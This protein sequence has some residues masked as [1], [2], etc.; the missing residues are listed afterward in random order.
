MSGK[1]REF[2]DPTNKGLIIIGPHDAVQVVFSFMLRSPLGPAQAILWHISSITTKRSFPGLLHFFQSLKR[3]DHL[4]DL[5][6]LSLPSNFLKID[7]WIAWPR[8]LE[9]VMAAFNPRRPKVLLTQIY[10]IVKA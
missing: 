1:R 6:W 8:H 9:Y 4:I 2:Q 7:S 10:E 3:S 5:I